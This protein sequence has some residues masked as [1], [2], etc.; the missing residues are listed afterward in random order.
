LVGAFVVGRLFARGL[1][2]RDR[3]PDQEAEQAAAPDR[4]RD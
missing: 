1:V 4:P 2:K 3:N